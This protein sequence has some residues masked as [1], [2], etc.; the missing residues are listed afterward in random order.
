MA[1]TGLLVVTNLAKIAESLNAVTKY[2]T[3][4]LYIQFYTEAASSENNNEHR[5]S[6]S[7]PKSP[8][9]YSKHITEIYSE[10][11]K[12]HHQLD[13]IVLVGN[14]RNSS[15]WRAAPYVTSKRVDLLIFDRSISKDEISQFE[16]RYQTKNVVELSIEP[17]KDDQK[18]AAQSSSCDAIEGN[19]VVLGG[20]FDRL[21][22]AH[23]TLLT[24][25]VLHAK[26]CVYVAVTDVNMIHSKLLWELI[27]PVET[28]MSQ[29]Q[30][31]LMAIDNTLTYDVRA[32]Q[33]MI[34]PL[35]TESNLD[36]L[37][38]SRETITGAN[39]V[40]DIRRANNLPEI[41]IHCVD[42]IDLETDE[43]GKEKKVSSS[44]QRMDLLGTRLKEP[45]PNP[46][47]P[48]YPYIV[49]LT[50]GIAS[51]KS[52]I[53]LYFEEL[54]AAVISCDE[55]CYEI[56]EPGKEC[57]AKVVAH[58]GNGILSD[59]H[60]IDRKKL[61]AIVLE[62]NEKIR[63][64]QKILWPGI[65]A[66]LQRRIEKIRIEKTHNIVIIEGAALIETDWTQTMHEIWSVIIPTGEALHRLM[67]GN[68]LTEEQAK[69]RIEAQTSNKTIVD[70][71]NV[72]F[73]T[74]WSS[75]HTRRQA[76]KAWRG[77]Q[78]HLSKFRA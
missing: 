59:D 74:Q 71:S 73:S 10:S 42:L 77:L 62:D 8:A 15:L 2:V 28:R 12:M 53:S 18:I 16:D 6:A 41:Q 76:E 78:E 37:V 36:V 75:D 44:N 72:V 32:I 40:N 19:I 20:T 29:V 4:T 47:L 54:G 13:V 34:G 11:V 1:R 64:L 7:T 60:R 5:K 9:R 66:E 27:Q 39:A 69:Q 24:E 70:E 3:N 31:F 48:N 21:H 33:D 52:K 57:H 22:V 35:R 38:V 14:L 58:F 30:N 61:D 25:A 67:N 65:C 23:K 26:Q 49:G 17:D 56:Y 55:L 46:N 63:E 43:E 45:E 50:G 51:G 68:G